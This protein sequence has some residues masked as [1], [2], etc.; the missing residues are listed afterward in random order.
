MDTGSLVAARIEDGLYLLEKLVAS[1]FD[2]SAAAWVKT[3]DD[4]WDLYVVSKVVDQHGTLRGYGMSGAILRK[5][6]PMPASEDRLHLEPVDGPFAR[7][8][9]AIRKYVPEHLSVYREWTPVGEFTAQEFYLYP[10]IARPLPGQ[11]P[12]TPGE[13]V[14]KVVGLMS[15][16]GAVRPSHVTLRDG[17]EFF[18]VPFGIE[19]GG[20]NMNVKFTVEGFEPPRVC[21]VEAI[22]V[23]D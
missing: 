16:N 14:Q 4:R 18:G 5:I 17:T 9:F 21:P 13:V 6:Q 12:L 23:I 11:E 2:V 15:R 10:A 20:G 7:S 1:D 3:S 19:K 8:V 22:Q